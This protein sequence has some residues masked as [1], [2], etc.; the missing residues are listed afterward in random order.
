M[1]N[2]GTCMRIPLRPPIR[3]VIG[4]GAG[5]TSMALVLLAGFTATRAD[6]V[7][8]ARAKCPDSARELPLPD[9]APGAQTPA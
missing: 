8:E 9:A 4:F 1:A 2:K 3:L 5:A 6:P 7:L